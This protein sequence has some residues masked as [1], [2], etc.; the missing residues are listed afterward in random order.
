MRDFLDQPFGAQLGEFVTERAR[1]SREV[2]CEPGQP[3]LGTGDQVVRLERVGELLQGLRITETQEG[4][5]ILLEADALFSWATRQPSVLIQID[6]G[7][8]P[9]LG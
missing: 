4:I 1:H 8:S 3:L 2:K 7:R 9:A 6:T 5:R